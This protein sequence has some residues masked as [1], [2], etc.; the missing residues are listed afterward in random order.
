[1][2]II[3]VCNQKGGVG[4]STT[5]YNLAPAFTQMGKS[6]LIIDADPQ[7]NLTS[8]ASQ[9][10][11]P[12]DALGL[13]D[14]LYQHKASIAEVVVPSIWKQVELLPTTG[15][16]LSAIRDLIV[17]EAIGRENHLKDAL[18]AYGRAHTAPDIVL[19]D[20]PPSL[21]QLTINALTASTSVLLVT[22]ASKFSHKGLTELCHN[23]SLVQEYYNKDLAIAGMLVNQW[24]TRNLGQQEW[25]QELISFKSLAQIDMLHPFIP[26]RVAISDSMAASISLSE[27]PGARLLAN[28]YQAIASQ[29]TR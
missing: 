20:C 11:V 23:I 10:N 26:K 6:V 2:E 5:V 14:V 1:M 3:A 27:W 4:K 29:L 21:D 18:N 9:E 17:T 8:V 7:G 15:P 28:Q 13:A 12:P 25:L 22:H 19:I 24:E 16:E